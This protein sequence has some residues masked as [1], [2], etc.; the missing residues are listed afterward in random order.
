MPQTLLAL[1]ALVLAS[2]FAFNTQ[3]RSAASARALQRSEVEVIMAGVA[4]GTFDVLADVPFDGVTTATQASDLTAPGSFGGRTWATAVDLDD[5]D[6]TSTTVTRTV[7][8]S[9]ISVTMAIEVD[10]VVKSGTVFVVS[11]STRQLFKRVTLTFTGPLG[12][13]ATLERIYA[14]DGL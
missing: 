6:G 1:L 14:L 11:P 3:Q 2:L 12:T 10:Y 8:A 9:S 7:G 4:E 5:Y 13:T